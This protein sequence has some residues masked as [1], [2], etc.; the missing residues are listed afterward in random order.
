[1][2]DDKPRTDLHN[3]DETMNKPLEGIKII[4]MGRVVAAPWCTQ[5]LGDMGADVIKIERPGRGDELRTY[6]PAFLKDPSGKPTNDS[7][8]YLTVNRNKR[9]ITVDFTKPQGADLIRNLVRDA[10]IF[11][12]NYKVGDLA[13][14]GLDYA[15]LATVNP[16]LVYCSITGF[17]QSGPYAK[18]GGLDGLF[19]GMSGMMSVTGEPDSAPQRVGAFVID[20][21]TGMYASTAIL[22]ALRHREVNGGAGQHIDLALLDVG[23]AA[24]AGRSIEYL[25]D[26][27]V[28]KAL[29]S[30]SPGSTPAQIFKCRNGLLNIQA[31]A[32]HHYR[33]LCDVLGHPE[34]KED[35]RFAQRVDRVRNEA[36]LIPVLAA[37]I[38]QRDVNELFEALVE[39]NVI[40][41]P[42]YT[43]DQ[44]MADPHVQHR[45]LRRTLPHPV[46]GTVPIIANPINFSATPLDDYRAPPTL[47]E[48]TDQVLSTELGL[49]SIQIASLRECG[50]I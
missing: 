3:K 10:D 20:E 21:L 29:G 15:S 39:R 24:M 41:A 25:I 11:V 46:A 50:A 23:V 18:R 42:I 27:T 33:A 44:S 40:A 14:Y 2:T 9:S 38:A 5:V 7:G 43:V 1:M 48:H 32:E 6:G 19:Q 8:H 34:L 17:G 16:G 30:K 37:A 12:E 47:G 45:K 31:G 49:S 28:P 35:P 26:G 36:E 22:A 4:D 13:R